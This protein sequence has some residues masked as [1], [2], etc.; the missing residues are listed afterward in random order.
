MPG[1]II[2]AT[3][4]HSF[5]R[6][7]STIQ[8]SEYVRRLA[9]RFT[10]WTKV[11]KT[12]PMQGATERL[13]WFLETATIDPVGPAGSGSISF[14]ELVTQQ[15]VYPT[16]RHGKGIK[17]ERDQ[18]EF[19]DGS[20]LNT[21][22]EWSRMVGNEIAYVPQRLMAQMILN[23]GNTDGSANAYD[24]CPFFVN[25]VTGAATGFTTG[26]PLNPFNPSIG[27]YF[28]WLTGSP[29]S[30]YP[31]DLPID[32][33]VTVDQALKNLGKIIAWISTVKMPNGKDPRMLS[34]VFI[35]APPAM[36]PR[37]RQLTHAKVL[38]MTA[39]AYGGHGGGSADVEALITGWGLGEPIIAQ[40]LQA[41][42]SYSTK[43][44]VVVAST[45]NTSF[46]SE[47]VTGSDTT[48]YIFCVE[49]STS[50]LGAL[51]YLT[52][53][54]FQVRYYTGD[55]GGTGMDA[56]LN[57]ANEFEYHVQ[58]RISTGFGHPY[59]LFKVGP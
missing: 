29:T 14:E 52:S 25:P 49:A 11:S 51:L 18:L 47:T 9:D 23:G 48:F 3:F 19:L 33:T 56:V 32:D 35:L 6:R 36:A 39:G 44:P 12:R 43:M 5:E 57:R 58:G 30:S 24:G 53:S 37:L 26:H 46:M 42:Q 20:G 16:F 54:P 34:P 13:A 1:N 28:N 40:E 17:V 45:G 55:T 59:A 7:M 27:G 15:T 8:E 2:D 41:S 4:V 38:A 21:L 31:G 10:W 50:Q 22:A